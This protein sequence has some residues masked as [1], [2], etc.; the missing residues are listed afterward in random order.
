MTK[1]RRPLLD[2]EKDEC[3]ALKAALTDFN[4]PRPKE[5]KLTQEDIA[6]SLG[7]SQG[8]LGS[9]L[10]G[11]RAIS[12]KLAIGMSNLLRIPIES[13]S[14]RLAKELTDLASAAGLSQAPVRDETL[15]AQKARIDQGSSISPSSNTS[16]ADNAERETLKALAFIVTVAANGSLPAVHAKTILRIRDDLARATHKNEGNK[17]PG[18]LEGIA[19]AAFS[20]AENGGNPDDL[21]SMLEHGMNKESHKEKG[22]KDVR[23]KKPNTKRN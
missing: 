17:L 20:V 6:L 2:W 22:A 16:P 4:A 7:M 5:K 21:I 11:Y 9:H 14:P 12:Q 19:S 15:A 23:H 3:A 8:T 13:F 10:N 18:N 1:E